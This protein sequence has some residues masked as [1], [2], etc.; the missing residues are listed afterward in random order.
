MGMNITN[1]W[2]LFRYGV[3]RDHYEKLISIRELSQQLYQDFFKNPFSPYRGTPAKNT[4]PLDNV[5]YGDIVSTFR[6]LHF[7]V[8]FLPPQRS[9]LFPT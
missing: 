7:S 6:A 5:D 9:A 8:V 1:C 2:K 3:K 4:P